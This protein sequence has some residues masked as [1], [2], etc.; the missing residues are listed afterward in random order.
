MFLRNVLATLLG[1]ILFFV[2]LVL[3]FIGIV[4]IASRDKEVTIDENSVLHLRLDQPIVERTIDDPFAEIAGILGDSKTA[5]S[6]L[7]IKKA[8]QDAKDNENIK[9]IFLEPRLIQAGYAKLKEIRDDLVAFKE[10]G[11]FILAY[12]EYLS[13][14]DYYLA[15]T[16]DEIY[17]TPLGGVEFNGLRAQSMFFKGSLEKLEIEAQVFKVGSYKSAA[18]PFTNEKMSDANREQITALVNSMYETF[19]GDIAE[20]L[21]LS[22]DRLQQISDSMLVRNAKQAQD[23]GLITSTAY[24][25]EVMANLR[26]KLELEEDDKI[27]MVSIRK[28]SGYLKS[29]KPKISKNRVA[30][31]VAE[32]EILWG[33]GDEYTIGSERF[34]K[35][36]RKARKNDRIKAIVLRI[37]SPGGSALASDVIWREIIETTKVKPVI[38]S[39]SDLAASGGYYLAMGCDTIVA[40]P[41]TL[42][43][44]IGVIGILFNM[45][46]FLDHKLGITSDVVSTGQYSDFATPTRPLTDGEKMIFQEFV[47]EIYEVFTTKAAEG[48]GMDIED[49]K[50]VAQGRVWSGEQAAELGLID[51]LGNYDDA[52][53][54]AADAAGLGDDYRVNIYPK[55]KN[56]FEQIM[57]ELSGDFENSYL[58]AK[59][60]ELYP[61]INRVKDIQRYKGVQA[62]LPYDL[63][64]N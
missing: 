63:V 1:L 61:Y 50:K 60:G 51:I 33:K 35:E 41:T 6:L 4:S 56:V 39:M 54:I 38:A 16:A 25:D 17:I 20:S 47:D 64:I 18:E 9:G 21:D 37:N 57:T 29:A 30:V 48:R 53:Q 40:Q 19:L 34:A 46:D 45:Q 27:K 23:L 36:I 3:I 28:Y 10:S 22:L 42:T 7:D 8:I 52:I 13:E 12:G 32:G 5:V 58:E 59:F 49:L 15:S 62:R 24:Y 2:V 31:I 44:S 26:S 55:P 14:K 43:G 11:K